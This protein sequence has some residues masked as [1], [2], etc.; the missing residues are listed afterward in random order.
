MAVTLRQASALA[1]AA[2]AMALACGTAE[3]PTV[4]VAVEPQPSVA[5]VRTPRVTANQPAS[6]QDLGPIVLI[7]T[8][9]SNATGA[10]KDGVPP[11]IPDATIPEWLD[12]LYYNDGSHAFGPLRVSP[13][14]LVFSHE[15]AL[16]ERLK[17]A[18]FRVAVIKITKGAT[19]ANRWT[20]PGAPGSAASRFYPELSEAL[21]ALPAQFP[22]AVR[23]RFVVTWDQGEA[24]ARSSKLDTVMSWP[25]SFAAIKKEIWARVHAQFPGASLLEPFVVRTYTQITGGTFPGVFPKLQAS[26]VSQPN[27]L[28]DSDDVGYRSDGVHRLG[29]GQLVIGN[30]IADVAIAELRG[31]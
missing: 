2:A 13:H 23:Y 20:P 12:D 31:G 6:P 5:E 24:E 8:G 3:G 4:A 25:A 1:T 16:A 7:T 30:R 10:D 18:G 27:H 9:Q 14:G 17:G 26:V 22:R 15:L 19:F 28:I 11:G 29:T 21:A